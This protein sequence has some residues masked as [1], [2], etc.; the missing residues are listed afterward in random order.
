MRNNDLLGVYRSLLR[1]EHRDLLIGLGVAAFNDTVQIFVRAKQIRRVD[2]VAASRVGDL[3]GTVNL[4][5][6]RLDSASDGRRIHFHKLVARFQGE[7]RK[8]K[9]YPFLRRRCE[10]LP[11]QFEV[12]RVHRNRIEH[13]RGTPSTVD[14]RNLSTCIEAILDLAPPEFSRTNSEALKALRDECR[15]AVES[16]LSGEKRKSERETV[17]SVALSVDFPPQMAGP[18]ASVLVRPNETG[19]RVEFQI[20]S[21]DGSFTTGRRRLDGECEVDVRLA[22]YGENRFQVWMFD[23][24]GVPS[25]SHGPFGIV[26]TEALPGALTA[27]RSLLL[28]AAG[29]NGEA[30]PEW[31]VRKGDPLPVEGRCAFRISAQSG[32]EPTAPSIIV[33][34]SDGRDLHCGLFPLGRI[35]LPPE[36]LPKGGKDAEIEIRCDY[37][38]ADPGHVQLQIRIPGASPQ[39]RIERTYAYSQGEAT[40]SAAEELESESQARFVPA[41]HWMD[42]MESWQDPDS[43]RDPSLI[44]AEDLFYGLQSELMDL[45]RQILGFEPSD[46]LV[47]L[48][49]WLG[50]GG[51]F[52]FVGVKEKRILMASPQYVT[53][54]RE[55]LAEAATWE[56]DG[57]VS[58]VASWPSVSRFRELA[59]RINAVPLSVPDGPQDRLAFLRYIEEGDRA[60]RD[61]DPDRLEAVVAA[62]SELLPA[63]FCRPRVYPGAA[64]RPTPG[65][66]AARWLPLGWEAADCA[67]GRKV[68]EGQRWQRYETSMGHVVVVTRELA[69]WWVE[70]GL[71]E[72]SAMTQMKLGDS[73]Y[74]ALADESAED[75]DLGDDDLIVMEGLGPIVQYTPDG[76][77]GARRLARSV[78]ESR[79]RTD[80]SFHDAI[81]SARLGRVLPTLSGT[82]GQT[83]DVVLGCF[84][85]G[86]LHVPASSTERMQELTTLDEGQI[87]EVQRTARL[88][89][90]GDDATNPAIPA[91]SP[92]Q[93]VS[94]ECARF[95]L[96]GRLALETFFNEE[97]IE[98]VQLAE[99]DPGTIEWPGSVVLYGPPG[100]GKTFAVERLTAFLGWEVFRI[101]AGTVGSPFIHETA[102]KVAEVFEKAREAAPS[103]IVID[104][105]EA[106]LSKRESGAS[107][108]PHHLEEVGEFLRRIEKASSQRILVLGMTNRLDLI[109]D[110]A[111]RSGRFDHHVEV[112]MP[113]AE[114]VEAVLRE[115]LRD[116]EKAPAFTLKSAVEALS[117]RPLA[118]AAFLVRCLKRRMRKANER[119]LTN[120]LLKECIGRLRKPLRKGKRSSIG[121]RPSAP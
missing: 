41:G 6:E 51:E 65:G 73:E 87:R 42:L 119:I 56:F 10:A 69:D 20:D 107:S 92:A 81:Y 84:L 35:L 76:F 83:D 27:A 99:R 26:R 29:Q 102:R 82:P 53:L 78:A 57:Q 103:V 12:L 72:E 24:S 15:R 111:L 60:L 2:P 100:S 101:D 75:D 70:Q 66:T 61:V 89:V 120:T 114:E 17:G 64:E 108:R 96:P 90:V 19:R 117:G 1:H 63:S 85:T 97:I 93:T 46:T 94:E 50:G 112:G 115:D 91:G 32:P 39:A 30:A 54:L 3:S 95:R 37:R 9:G 98:D 116:E 13:E 5:K 22:R 62:M 11:S 121:F 59:S 44:E 38:V 36:H 40:K 68:D 18:A 55:A 110:A 52:E 28:S 104:E 4:F 79:L 48:D 31:L 105:M 80:A 58:R 16:S 8:R 43:E 74:A 88:P 7:V 23:A 67:V 77:D 71:L 86:G 47:P 49:E 109:E 106:F 25:H 118:D 14:V 45:A 33:C 34:E 21:V 113:S